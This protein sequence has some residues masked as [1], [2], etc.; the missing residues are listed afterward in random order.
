MDPTEKS[1]A[2]SNMGAFNANVVAAI[3][4]IFDSKAPTGKLPVNIPELIVNQDGS[5]ECS[6]EFLF[7]RGFGLTY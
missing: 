2:A 4:T 1:G 5:L 7:E 6:S 3:E